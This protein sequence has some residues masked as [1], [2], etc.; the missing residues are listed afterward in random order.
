[1]SNG[2]PKAHWF[3]LSNP[4]ISWEEY[5]K[6]CSQIDIAHITST[7]SILSTQI[8]NILSVLMQGP[9]DYVLLLVHIFNAKRL[10]L[11]NLTSMSHEHWSFLKRVTS[12]LTDIVPHSIQPVMKGHKLWLVITHE[13]VLTYILDWCLLSGERITIANVNH[14]CRQDHEIQ[15]HTWYPEHCCPQWRDTRVSTVESPLTY[16]SRPQTDT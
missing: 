8:Q 15:S 2:W 14:I 1:M 7:F 13:S 3:L 6:P 12:L 5:K 4:P 9:F 10:P 11:S 16:P